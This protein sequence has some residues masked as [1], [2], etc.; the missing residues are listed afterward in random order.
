[1]IK[2]GVYVLFCSLY[3]HHI[4]SHLV[5]YDV[6]TT[7]KIKFI[8]AIFITYYYYLCTIGHRS[9]RFVLL[10]V[11]S[12]GQQE[13]S[14]IEAI[15]QGLKTKKDN[16]TD[17]EQLLLWSVYYYIGSISN[18]NKKK[19]KVYNMHILKILSN[20]VFS[21]PSPHIVRLQK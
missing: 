5:N 16:K 8:H 19:K 18:N 10:P 13:P 9:Q 6:H 1:M 17:V 21:H 2:N 3:E 4:Y 20:V 15:S 14:S 11:S 7:R 12:G